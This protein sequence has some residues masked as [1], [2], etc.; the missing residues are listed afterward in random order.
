M[1]SNKYIV[2]VSSIAALENLSIFSVQCYPGNSLCFQKGRGILPLWRVRFYTPSILRGL[3]AE[4]WKG[5]VPRRE[6]SV[7]L[8]PLSDY[9]QAC[10]YAKSVI[11][12]PSPKLNTRGLL[13]SLQTC[14][15][16][17][18]QGNDV[19]VAYFDVIGYLIANKE[20]TAV[21]VFFLLLLYY[22]FLQ[23]STV[24]ES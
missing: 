12:H 15:V 7:K 5:T 11:C 16:V 1:D 20:W 6:L 10:W 8:F 4:F 24:G 13:E 22:Y 17:S 23:I 14:G 21:E 9:G 18:G 2:K 19:P 3:D